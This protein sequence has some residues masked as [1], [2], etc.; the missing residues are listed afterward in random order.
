[1]KKLLTLL[2]LTSCAT[3]PVLDPPFDN[4]QVASLDAV[5]ATSYVCTMPVPC[6]FCPPPIKCPPPIICPICPPPPPPPPPPPAANT[7][8][9]DVNSALASD[10]NPC[11]EAKPCKSIQA[12]ANLTKPGDTVLVKA[13]TYYSIVNGSDD[14]YAGVVTI[15]N[16]GTDTAPITYKA[17]GKV[18]LDAK[19]EMTWGMVVSSN[20]RA[21][22]YPLMS[23]IIIDG[24]EVINANRNGI[25]LFNPVN[26]TVRN[27]SLHDNNQGWTKYGA[28]SYEY[29]IM[30]IGGQNVIIEANRIYNNGGGINFYE[31][32]PNLSGCKACI[33]RNNFVYANANSGNI[34]NSSGIA[35]RFTEGL[36][37]SD[38]IFY[39]GADAN[40]N[41]L[42]A[43]HSKF[44]RN[45]LLNAWQPGGNNEGIKFAVR[46]GGNNL[47]AGNLIAYNGNTGF[48]ATDGVGDIFIN[49][50]IYKNDSWGMLMEGSNTFVL[51]NISYGHLNLKNGGEFPKDFRP[52][53]AGGKEAISVESSY[54]LFGDSEHDITYFLEY[55]MPH[56]LYAGDP[57]FVNPWISLP[58]TD[59]K[60]V[61]HPE[62]IFKD[63]NGDG[64]ISIAEA[65]ADAAARFG[66]K[67][68]SLAVGYGLSVADISALV[69][70]AKPIVVA[71]LNARILAWKDDPAF[72]RQQAVIMWKRI[73]ADF[74]SGK[75]I[76]GDI[77]A[78]TDLVGK[79]MPAKVT[80]GAIQQ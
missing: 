26:V 5:S 37:V 6:P 60:Q 40:I 18:I 56:T 42:G 34:G 19:A 11:T 46:G 50:T 45:V 57:K 69:K 62:Q 63:L 72:Q 12:A 4:T 73:L 76:M 70:A 41:G 51:N 77:P 67:G 22:N 8:T 28:I 75:V 43:I 13:G 2:L 80:L 27:T 52:P 15:R 10:T 58:R 30:I 7:L 36:E 20:N 9:V 33:A 65:K 68:D 71:K 79:L 44:I 53:N 47:V 29:G 61:I 55:V 21:D 14:A 17:Q 66:L 74:D 3:A 38:N 24:F 16:N 54:N 59:P 64:A 48:D 23:N 32:D 39:D 25:K 31:L 78:L 1:M 35:C 49:N